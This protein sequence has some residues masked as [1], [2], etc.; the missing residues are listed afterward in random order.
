MKELL[1]EYI[2]KNECVPGYFAQKDCNIEDR[3]TD[4]FGF[5]VW[6]L[7]SDRSDRWGPTFTSGLLI[8]FAAKRE[9]GRDH[10]QGAVISFLPLF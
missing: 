6:K 9:D 7:V 5:Q 2:H 3:F 1:G 8:R 4:I 10:F